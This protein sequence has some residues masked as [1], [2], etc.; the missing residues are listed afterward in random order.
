MILS[1]LSNKK[2]WKW[3]GFSVAWSAFSEKNTTPILFIHGFGANS[4]H[5]RK[6]IKFF[7]DQG[8]AV[9]V[10]DLLGFGDSDQPG[11]YQIGKLDNGIWCDQVT[12]FINEIIRPVNTNKIFLV[13]NSLGGLVALTCAVSISEDIAGIV[14]SPLPDPVSLLDQAPILKTR[15]KNLRKIIYKF[16]INIIPFKLI[17]FL[18]NRLGIIN[19]GLNSAYYKKENIDSELLK[20][21][22]RPAK[23]NTASRALKAMCLGMSLRSKKLKASFLLNCLNKQKKVP[24]LLIWGDKDNFIPLFL[25]K[26]IAKIYQ[27]V[28]LI[29]ITNSGHCVHDEDHYKFNKIV[30]EWIKDLK[31]F[32]K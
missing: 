32:K 26:R 2:Y 11:I 7:S 18:V 27:W 22:K 1:I 16:I 5:W 8:Y 10:L 17:L 12:D 23:R 30:H 6:N 20:I 15:F 28:K 21:I 3:K 25:G 19:L 4:E 29:V 13:G 14:A 31:E 24:F 9:Y